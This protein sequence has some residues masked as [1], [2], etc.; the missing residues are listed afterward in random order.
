MSAFRDEL[1]RRLKERL[2]QADA[3]QIEAAVERILRHKLGQDVA[4]NPFEAAMKLVPTA[5]ETRRERRQRRAKKAGLIILHILTGGL[6]ALLPALL[7]KKGK[8]V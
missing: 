7:A 4:S 5:K 6:S 2:P 1:R 3:G 8:I